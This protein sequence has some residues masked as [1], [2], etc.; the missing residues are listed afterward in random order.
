MFDRKVLFNDG[1]Y[2][3]LFTP[4]A[5]IK[6]LKQEFRQQF[7]WPL[8][9]EFFSMLRRTKDELASERQKYL[10]GQPQS[11]TPGSDPY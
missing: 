4:F 11:N 7:D 8:S 5:V 3:K 2:Y 1:E 10:S 6:P 9:T